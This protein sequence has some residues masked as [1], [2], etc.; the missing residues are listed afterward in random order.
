MSTIATTVAEYTR[1]LEE[2]VLHKIIQCDD[3][4]ATENG[5]DVQFFGL[6]RKD[7]LLPS[8][9]TR[10]WMEENCVETTNWSPTLN[11]KEDIINIMSLKILKLA[12]IPP[13][14]LGVYTYTAA[15][16]PRFGGIH[17]IDYCVKYED[18]GVRGNDI[19]PSD[20]KERENFSSL[21]QKDLQEIVDQ[22]KR[23]GKSIPKP[24]F[25][26]YIEFSSSNGDDC[27]YETV[28][29]VV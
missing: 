23:E 16:Y 25:D 4:S 26:K 19:S 10:K 1:R 27:Q 13:P 11:P 5:K 29:V 18:F 15:I 17:V 24:K 6:V 7:V 20:M 9:I 12:N 3:P 2:K 14:R 8:P 22:W 28:R 21:L